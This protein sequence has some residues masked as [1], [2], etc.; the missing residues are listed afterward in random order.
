MRVEGPNRIG[1]GAYGARRVSSG[2]GFSLPDTETSAPLQKPASAASAPG[3]DALLALQSVDMTVERRKKAT[4]RGRTI[5]DLLDAVKLG[6]LDGTLTPAALDGLN[7][8]VGSAREAT[9]DPALEQIL[10]E[11]ELRAQVELAKLQRRP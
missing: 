10:D 5:L 3:L 11:I 7:A 4:Q 1:Q 8:A 9:E 6:V 2:S